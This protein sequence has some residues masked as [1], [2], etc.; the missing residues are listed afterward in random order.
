MTLFRTA[1]P[2]A[3]PVTVADLKNH[4]RVDHASDDVLIA[5]LIGAAREEVERATGMALIDQEWRL[6]LD[7]LPVSGRVLLL[8]HPVRQVLTVT[9]YGIGGEPSVIAGYEADL[10][11]RP[12]RVHVEPRPDAL[13]LFNGIEIDFVAGFGEAGTDVPD[14]LCRAVR[15]LAAHWYEFRASLGAADQPASYPAGYEQ[16]IA[17]YRAR[18]L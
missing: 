13:R 12:A 7:R 6:A 16:L 17:G 10:K 5:G 2:L 9:A 14:G 8:R 1:E 18:R 11:S 3:E 15:L 4:L